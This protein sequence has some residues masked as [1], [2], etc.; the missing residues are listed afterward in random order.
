MLLEEF[1]PTWPQ[2][3]F[4]EN[5]FTEGQLKK[6][7]ENGVRKFEF[8]DTETGCKVV[9]EMDKRTREFA[10]CSLAFYLP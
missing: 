7:W 10:V 1:L 5:C 2:F 3:P 9:T 8:I 6:L 4:T